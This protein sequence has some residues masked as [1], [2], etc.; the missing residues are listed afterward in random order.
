M[1]VIVDNRERE[2]GGKLEEIVE[3]EKRQLALGDFIIESEGHTMIIER[4][5]IDDMSAS[6]TDGRYEEQKRRLKEAQEGADILY[7]VEGMEKKS[8]KGV[9][10]ST[11]ISAILSCMLKSKFNVMRTKNSE[12]TAKV[13]KTIHDKMKEYKEGEERKGNI[14][15]KSRSENVSEED[16]QVNML[17]CIK[18]IN[19]KIAE[20]IIREYISVEKLI[21]RFKEEGKH[22]LCKMEK[23]GKVKSEIVYGGLIRG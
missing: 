5:T 7:I 2:I 9:P 18:G 10:Y 13:I 8:R 11:V 16:I 21:E 15:V 3:I 14:K 20:K 1:V 23:I 12:E 6:I 19:R 22:M 4:K 17:C